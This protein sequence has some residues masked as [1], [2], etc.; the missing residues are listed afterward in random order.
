MKQTGF[1]L[2]ELIITVAIV[3]ILAAIAI[4][5]YGYFME[6]ARRSDAI[7]SLLALQLDQ[8]AWRHKDADYATLQE[9]G[10][11][12]DSLDGYYSISL[13]QRSAN[14]FQLVAT[15]KSGGPQKNDACGAFAI[16][17]DGPVMTSGYADGACWR[18]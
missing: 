11:G 17:Q 2:V 12:A 9:L 3:A 13:A 1:T 14:G 6:K 7:N 8:A 10:W 4:P 16:D 15:P 18:R 5:G